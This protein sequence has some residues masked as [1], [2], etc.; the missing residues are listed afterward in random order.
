MLQK[1]HLFYSFFLSRKSATNKIKEFDNRCTLHCIFFIN[2]ILFTYHFFIL[3]SLLVARETYAQLSDGP[4]VQP[5]TI[6]SSNGELDITLSLE[7]ADHESVVAS[8]FHTRLFD[9]RLPGPTLAIRRGEWLRINFQNELTPQPDA[10]HNHNEFSSPDTSNLHFHGAH[11][12]GELPSDDVTYPIPPQQSFQ[13]QSFFPEFHM[14]GKL[15]SCYLFIIAVYAANNPYRSSTYLYVLT[16][17]HRHALDPST[18]SRKWHHS[19]WW[20]RCHGIDC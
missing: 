18:S 3:L 7:E 5:P 2:M 16:Y 17:H 1:R 15:F 12:S 6:E 11:V 13:Y 8:T 19:G 10:N 4:L 9:G 14:P 20:G